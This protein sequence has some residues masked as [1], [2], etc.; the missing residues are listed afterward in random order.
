PCGRSATISSSGVFWGWGFAPWGTSFDGGVD[1]DEQL[2]DTGD[3]GLVVNLAA[4]L[5]TAVLGNE[6]FVPELRSRPCGIEEGPTNAAAAASDMAL[7]GAFTGLVVK[8]G[9]A[10]QGRDLFAADFSEFGQEDDKGQGSADTDAIDAGDQ[11][12]AAGEIV[13]FA[14]GGLQSQQLGVAAALL[15]LDVAIDLIEDPFV[16]KVLATGLEASDVKLDLFDEEQMLGERGQPGIWRLTQI[17]QVGGALGDES[18]IDAVV[19]GPAQLVDGK[20]TDLARLQESDFE[21]VLSQMGH[22]GLL[23][24]TGCLDTH[25]FDLVCLQPG[26]ELMVSV[27]VVVDAQP[28][29]RRV[30]CDVEI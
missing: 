15:G 29:A 5:E 16:D 1:E 17:T 24:A 2:S 9:D 7:A 18:G 20:G 27:A 14:Q 22:H 12:E 21:A 28:V 3:E 30:D 26:D 13:V 6:G 10:D 8:G 4:A 23:V 25:A 19:L 11:L